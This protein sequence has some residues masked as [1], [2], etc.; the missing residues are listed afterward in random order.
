MQR[1]MRNLLSLTICL[2]CLIF[3][4]PA[5][6]DS[7]NFSGLKDQ[8]LKQ[9]T[10]LQEVA[11]E[12]LVGGKGKVGPVRVI[13][14]RGSS[15]TVQI[16]YSD[17]PSS[18]ARTLTVTA[19]DKKLHRI[20]GISTASMNISGTEGEVTVKL[21]LNSDVAEGTKID[22]ALLVVEIGV[23][24]KAKKDALKAFNCPKKWEKPIAPENLIINLKAEP[25]GK[26]KNLQTNKTNPTPAFS[27]ALLKP[28]QMAKVTP[29]Q[30]PKQTITVMRI[31]TMKP[32]SVSSISSSA[33]S[34]SKQAIATMNPNLK[35]LVRPDLVVGLPKDVKDNNGKGP[36]ATAVRL[37]DVLK[38]DVGLTA[39]NI[40]DLHPNIYEDANPESGFFYYLPAAY[41]LYW[42]EDTGYALRILY[43]ASID[44]ANVNSV[45]VAARLT[46]GIDGSDISLVR[47]ILQKYCAGSGRKFKEL[48]PFPFSN[49]AVSLKGDLGQYNIPA[50]NISITGISDI[51]GMIDIS[52]TT[53][54]VTKEN[55]QMVLTE[56]LGVNGLVT[57]QSASSSGGGELEVSIPISIKFADRHSFGYRA[58]SRSAEV[59]NA[60][61]FPMK[62]KYVNILMNE[63][64]PTVYSYELG[65]T[66]VPSG[67]RAKIDAAK[68]PT[69][70]D[71]SSSNL[72]MWVDYAVTSDED[73]TASAI[74]AVTGG[75]T[76]V[77]QSKIT[78]RTLSPLADTE[79]ALV[80][81]TISSKY[82]DPKGASESVKTVELTQDGSTYDVGPIYLIDRQLGQEKPGDPLFKF[83]LT[84][85][86]P[87]GTSK[88]GTLW[89]ESNNLTIYIGNMQL[90]PIIGGE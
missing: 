21:S 6:T 25:I 66:E 55:L 13:E 89:T 63:A 37:F 90:Q 2:I 49:M 62:A 10:S 9:N 83:K 54:P 78:F 47:N 35:V 76:S 80:L 19:E 40:T 23:Q 22:Q 58:F 1:S 39:D 67:A 18:D 33:S 73:A 4:I 64:T 31:E 68:I 34:S 57:Y 85:V 56:G 43:G 71:T 48:K 59:K 79:A 12:L 44:P 86:N 50:E 87:D 3:A 46:S 77:A 65:G 53:D 5:A 36:S 7:I 75:V 32:L 29:Q 81:V 30:T 27:K 45:S 82:F 16:M 20:S 70:L 88:E 15:L 52:L 24:G 84:V 26:S 61:P 14:D 51:A 72:K 28:I 42:D 60:S 74:D 11:R 41:Y 17:L 69:W 8:E 38:S